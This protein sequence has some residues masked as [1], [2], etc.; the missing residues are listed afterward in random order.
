[1][2]TNNELQC[3]VVIIGDAA[4]GKTSL[5]NRFVDNTF[6]P[7]ELSTVGANY[8]LIARRIN[9]KKLQIQLWDTAGQEKFRSLAP[10][11]FR[12]AIGV[13][14]VFSLTSQASYDHLEDWLNMFT[15]IA[16]DDTV[17]SIVGN[18]SDLTDFIEVD[19]NKVLKDC[20]EKKYLFAKVSAQSGF[21]ISEFFSD[22]SECLLEK[23][24]QKKKAK[25]DAVLKANS[26]EGCSC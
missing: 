22:L 14:A 21:G 10:I 4:V 16:G 26:S 19:V 18:K 11:Y 12:N 8:Q 5:L 17:I 23:L 13:I 24:L 9:G 15:E 20:N 3:R 6:N 7:N 25:E 1:M 2:I